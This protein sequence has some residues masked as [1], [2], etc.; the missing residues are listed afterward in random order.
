[1]SIVSIRAALETALAAIST[2][3]QIAWENGPT[4]TPAPEIAYL[5]PYLLPARPADIT[6]GKGYR[7]EYGLY[8]VNVYYPAQQGSA[9]AAA[10]AELIKTS[11]PRGATFSNG[12][13]VVNIGGTPEIM[14][15]TPN[16]EHYMI[17]VRIP[18]WANI[19]SS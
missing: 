11:F 9:D 3:I 6:M 4:Y 8:Q 2:N 18:Y 14:G 15:G 17:P 7:R 10:R 12:G 5:R 16:G 19:L 13:I 1:M